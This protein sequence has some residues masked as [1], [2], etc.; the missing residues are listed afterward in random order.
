M[1]ANNLKQS[2]CGF[3]EILVSFIYGEID[4]SEKSLLEQHLA[5]CESCNFEF[6]AFGSVRNS[7]IE[8]RELGFEPLLTPEIIIPLP[9]KQLF[10]GTVSVE[11]TS[12][13]SYIRNLLTIAPAWASAGS[14]AVLLALV[15]G[16]SF[17]LLSFSRSDEITKRQQ[18]LEPA[19]TDL[20]ETVAN[21]EPPIV[22]EQSEATSNSVAA[23]RTEPSNLDV[24]NT[25][26][27]ENLIKASLND[28]AKKTSA[29]RKLNRTRHE[30]PSKIAI[31]EINKT[32][33]RNQVSSEIPK[34]TNFDSDEDDSLRLADLFEESGSK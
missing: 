27:A 26:S 30:P 25:L 33:N 1:S 4:A 16:I 23:T 12:W 7:I 14:F 6:S 29:K 11:Q 10:G 15:L 21:A 2:Q 17:A 22:S 9:S 8:W 28:P 20:E 18:V 3:E 32:Q 13:I 19:V 5:N 34:L 31:A 24:P